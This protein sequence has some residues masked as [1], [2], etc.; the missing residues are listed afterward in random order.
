MIFNTILPGAWE[1]TQDLEY[2]LFS[3]IVPTA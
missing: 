1:L 3:L 2:N